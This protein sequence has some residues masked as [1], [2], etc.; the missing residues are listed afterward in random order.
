M[1]VRFA[2]IAT[3][4][5]ATGCTVSTAGGRYWDPLPLGGD[6]TANPV[7]LDGYDVEIRGDDPWLEQQARQDVLRLFAGQRRDCD[8]QGVWIGVAGLRVKAATDAYALTTK[9]S[10][11][12]VPP[13]RTRVELSGNLTIR[14][15]A[16]QEQ[17][18]GSAV[19][20]IWIPHV[21]DQFLR[22]ERV[23][24]S[25]PD[26]ARQFVQQALMQARPC[27]TGSPDE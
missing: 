19:G 12:T 26:V 17:T 14:N 4:C 6:H 18:Q 8:D 13:A 9:G 16:Q 5:L 15:C 22:E 27:E 3:V 24:A 25:L 2:L 20:I 21:N 23:A 11:S 1:S 7:C 10:R